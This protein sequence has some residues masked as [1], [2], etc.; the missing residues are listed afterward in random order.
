MTEFRKGYAAVRNK[1]WRY[2]WYEDGSE[3]L[4]DHKND[5]AERVNLARKAKHQPV[6]AR[7]AKWIPKK[8]AKGAL[9]KNA[10]KFD[11]ATY[12]WKSKDTG[13]I[14]QGEKSAR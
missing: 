14:F 2:I 8:W 12:S 10:F 3:E 11:P 5:P 7:L 6:K 1:R 9:T 4:Y 13:K